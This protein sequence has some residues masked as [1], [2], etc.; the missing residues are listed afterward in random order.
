MHFQ[1]H[2]LIVAWHGFGIM[3]IEL[4]KLKNMKSQTLLLVATMVISCGFSSSQTQRL[5]TISDNKPSKTTPILYCGMVYFDDSTKVENPP[6]SVEKTPVTRKQT[7]RSLPVKSERAATP[8]KE[9]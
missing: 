1:L 6:K 7:K 3:S 4:P 5:E 8:R 2:I 9:D